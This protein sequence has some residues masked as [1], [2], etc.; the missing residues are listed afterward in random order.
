M[1][2]V[3]KYIVNIFTQDEAR[4]IVFVEILLG[5]IFSVIYL[6]LYKYITD[7][8][9]LNETLIADNFI[10][11]YIIS[12]RAPWLTFMM[13]I[14]SIL[15]SE[16]VVF[17]SIIFV[18]LLTHR[19]H[20]RE[21]FVFGVLLTMG[22]SLTSFLKLIYKVPRP[23]F[24]ALVYESSYSY[25]SGHALN[26]ILFYGA[27]AYFVYHFTKNQRRSFFVSVIAGILIVLIGVSRIY[28][29]VHR[30]SEVIAGFIAGFWLLV[31]TILVDKT[32]I[33]FRLIRENTNSRS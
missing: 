32:I 19:R 31:T 3:R 14:Y 21:S 15:G 33:Y 11:G 24:S 1:P 30:P 12:F 10:S 17:G 22:A 2:T 29:G 25:P 7:A 26:S 9:L 8:V 5:I 20:F 27:I 23:Y 18:I 28:L 16:A 13:R 4:S 6:F